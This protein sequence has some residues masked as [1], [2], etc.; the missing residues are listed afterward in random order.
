MLRIIVV[1]MVG[2]HQYSY[3]DSC[4]DT[5]SSTFSTTMTMAIYPKRAV[6]ARCC[7]RNRSRSSGNVAQPNGFFEQVAITTGSTARA[8]HSMVPPPPTQCVSQ[9]VSSSSP[10]TTLRSLVP[11]HP[12]HPSVQPLPSPSLRVL[13]DASKADKSSMATT[14]GGN[15]DGTST[16]TT[17]VHMIHLKSYDDRNRG[18]EYSTGTGTARGS[19][20]GKQ[21]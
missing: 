11:P 21:F 10:P 2:H 17:T 9:R 16:N 19:G 8:N 6:T 20:S 1:G 18:E 14:P 7:S 4:K 5:S 15:G 12:S 13:Y 3:S